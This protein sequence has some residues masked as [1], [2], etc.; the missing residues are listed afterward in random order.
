VLVKTLKA[1][2][3]IALATLALGFALLS[4]SW[5]GG[6]LLYTGLSW[7]FALAT[8]ALVILWRRVLV[9]VV[10]SVAILCAAL[11]IG[12]TTVPLQWRISSATADFE[13]LE[14]LATKETPAL[15]PGEFR[16][17]SLRDLNGTIIPR[18]GPFEAVSAVTVGRDS[19]GSVSYR[20]Q[21]NALTWDTQS[22]YWLIFSP[23][24]KSSTV[25]LAD[26]DVKRLSDHV[27]LARTGEMS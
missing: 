20:F 25:G 23:N 26:A 6:D 18:V 2:T 8:V 22:S 9:A 21:V 27:F 12:Q 15:K 4:S 3:A 5:P 17:I 1:A 13:S 24:G 19:D 10:V 7:F 16:E 11:V 14:S